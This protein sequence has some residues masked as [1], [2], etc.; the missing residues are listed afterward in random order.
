MEGSLSMNKFHIQLYEFVKRNGERHLTTPQLTAMMD[1]EGLFRSFANKPYKLLFRFMVNEGYVKRFYSWG[2]WKEDEAEKLEQEVGS[3]FSGNADIH[4]ALQS[5]AY[6]LGW[7]AEVDSYDDTADI[8]I[9][10]KFGL[11]E[12]VVE[13][14][15]H[16]SKKCIGTLIPS[17]MAMPVHHQ[18]NVIA[19]EE[20]SVAE[21]VMSEM[22]IATNKELE[23]KIS[24]EQIDGVAMAIRQMRNGRGFILGDMTGI[25]K[26]RQLAMLLK[27]ATLQSDRPVFVTEKSV[28]FNDL[29]RDLF[30][31]GYGDL[32]PFILNS[33]KEAKITDA[34]G[35]IIYNLPDELEIKEFRDTKR[36]PAGYDFLLLTYSQLSRDRSKNWKADCVMNTIEGAYLLMDESH[37]A[38]GEESNV[39]EFFREAVQKSCGVCFASATYAKYPSS[40]P[41]YA[42]KTA[43]GEAD[44]SATQL[45]DIISHGGPILQEVMA[46]GLVSSGSMIRR[47]RDMKDVERR[48]YTCDRVKDVVK[49][50]ERYDKVIDLISDIYD[51]QEEFISPYLRSLSAEQIVCKKHKVGKNEVFIRKKTHIAYMHFTLRMTPTI[52]QLLFSI[53]T[54]DAI[55]A[56]LDELKA[57][58]KP[59]IQI[60]RTMESNYTSLAQ[61]GTTMPKAEFALCLLNCLKDMFKYKALAATKKGKAVKYYEVEQTFDMKDLKKFFNNDEAK[62]AYDFLVKKINSTDTSLPLSPIDYFVQCLESKGYKV[63]EMTQRKTILKYENIKDGATGKTHAIMRKRIDKKRMA[64]DFNNGVLDVLIGNRVMSSGISLHC[65]DAFAD[66]RKRTVITWEYQDS[67]DRQTQFDG[68]ADRTGQ[69]QHCAFVTLSSVIPAEQRF[70]MMNERKLRSLNANVEANQ[71]ADDAGFDMLN[72]YGTKVAKEYLHDNPEK[73][74]YFADDG[75]DTFRGREDEAAFITRFMRTLG[76]LKCSEQKEILD[77]VMHRY[78][79]LIRYLDEIGEND[80]RPNVLPLNATL[81]SRTVF[82]NGKRNSASV[83]GNDAMLDEVEVDVLNKPLT[84]VQIKA[85]LPT[86]T[87][88]DVLLKQI[89]NYGKQKVANIRAYYTQLQ[90]DAAR[91]LNSLRS[92]GGHYTPSHLAQLEER[93]NNTDMMNA[94]IT[95]VET[96][97][98]LLCELLNKFTNGQAVGIP[99]ALVAD[100]EI[101]DNRLVDYVST[102]LF[103]GFKVV[104]SKT[105]RSSI[106]AVFAVNDGRCRLDIPL[107]EESKLMTIHNQTHLGVMRQRLSKVTLDTWDSLLS[108]STRERVYIVTGNLLSG[109]AYA[110]EFG[111]NVGNRKLRQLAMNKGRGHLVTYTDDMGR[112]KNGYMLSRMFR[113]TDIQLYA[114]KS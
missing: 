20:G 36:L 98:G 40:M 57:G 42:M 17:A 41:I 68:R 75:H 16:G 61:P 111:K 52:R 91:Q 88:T 69:L 92:L 15:A 31:I 13:Y 105:T 22:Q 50:Q 99:M 106:K 9:C 44:I 23:E 62:K 43:M 82:K 26:G 112:V 90:N 30:D 87:S 107:T 14:I 46:K 66:K 71:H 12:E 45:I 59:I 34:N 58:H 54:E 21:F 10:Q 84:S 1:D 6:A 53:K 8:N 113:P 93:A 27:W 60:N 89:K 80:L 95:K 39:G 51:F 108:N 86:L 83:F 102:G 104:G 49:V 32:R 11:K 3:R 72:K 100:G 114:P 7:I 2:E 55:Q 24:G 47:Q 81:L 65:S 110:K 64:S 25:G 4:Y 29:F 19:H 97:T 78:T 96:Q 94:Q 67:A 101:E 103:L 33:D 85:I 5:I 79:E 73:E 109:I 70:L 18:L 63:G 37:N 76:L 35:N 77:D 38:S 74:V 56:A 28:L 48:L